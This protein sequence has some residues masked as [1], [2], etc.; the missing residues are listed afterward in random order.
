MAAV[1]RGR[2]A[3]ERRA[4]GEAYA[5]LAAADPAE[6]GPDDLERLAVAAYLVGEEQ[7]SALAW[8]RAHDAHHA[9][10]AAGEAARC[11]VWLGMLHFLRGEVTRAG[12]WFA[13]AEHAGE[14]VQGDR[15]FALVAANLQA[16]LRGDM[17][18]ARSLGAEMAALG[19]RRGDHELLCW[20]LMCTGEAEIALGETGRGLQ[21]LD[22]AMVLLTAGE[23]PPIPAGVVCC[24][25]IDACM[26]AFDV[27]RAAEWT[28]A[29]TT[30]CTAQPDLVPFRG[31]CLVHR[32]QVMVARGAWADAAAEAERARRRL[33]EPPGPALGLA[34]YQQGEVHRLRGELAEAE[35]AYRAA[36]ASGQ[37]PAPGLALLRLAQGDAAAAAALVRRMLEE[38]R[39]APA[40]PAILGAAVEVL[41]AVDDAGAARA[42][43]DELDARAVPGAPPLLHGLAALARG[44]V[45]LAC[46]DAGEALPHLRRAC[47]IFGELDLPYEAARAEVRIG[48]A[49]RALRDAESADLALDAARATFERL[50]AGPD[51]AALDRLE[52]GPPA[53]PGP[54]TDRELEVLRLVAAGQT[55]REIAAALTISPHTVGRHL[56]NIFMKLG[57]SSRAAATAHA[58]EH[59]LT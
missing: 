14:D 23:L 1:G 7:A 4:W 20:G 36:A 25:A 13:R 37:D 26:A 47:R 29:L 54:L 27:R 32:S 33:S 49:C 5:A 22:E 48:M 17:D 58:Y 57:V 30:W 50:G 42:A 55:N 11:A 21:R 2:E 52:P 43:S 16:L 35:R 41:L 59:G 56:Q 45:L 51:L 3:F 19:R 53:L 40:R 24:A 34:C 12:G 8:E 6:L 31:Q 15:G 18:A 46:D 28:D 10:A 44:S 9:A 38:H 39:H